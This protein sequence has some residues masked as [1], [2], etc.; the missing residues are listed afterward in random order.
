M[1]ETFERIRNQLN[2]FWQGLDKSKKIKLGV[3]S[4]LL[5]V[6]ITG[7]I[8]FTTRTKY[9]VLYD[10]LT[11]KEAGEITKK[12]DEQG[13]TWKQENKGNTL[14]VPTEM[15]DKAKMDL[16]VEGLP[17]ER[18]SFDNA[19]SDIDWT[20]TEFDK[21]QKMKYALEN[22]LAKD[23]SS[24][25]GIESAEVHMK[26]PEDSGYVI[27]ETD[28]PTA[29]VYLTL[30]KN[31]PIKVSK[32][33]GIQHL[34]ANA[35]GGME[36]Q[37]VSIID[38]KGKL[39]SDNKG[40]DE[41][42]DLN[43]QLAIQQAMQEKLN[44]SIKEFLEKAFGP[45]NV[46]IRTSIKMNFDTEVTNVKEFKPP[47]E[48]SEEGIPRSKEESEESMDNVSGGQVPGTETNAQD[49][50]PEYV[51]TETG[52][53]KYNKNNS[54]I[55]YEINETNKQVK[56]GPGEI[57]SVSVAVLINEDVIGEGLTDEKKKEIT[58]LVSN[59]TAGA[60]TEQVEVSAIS[61]NNGQA[62]SEES[63]ESDGGLPLWAWMLVGALALAG[64]SGAVIY[65][66]KKLQEAEELEQEELENIMEDTIS[67][68]PEMEEIDFGS[69]KSQM[70]EQIS[71]FIDKKPEMV[72]QLLRTWLN[73]E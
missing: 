11:P 27:K 35:V 63:T 30:D 33:K 56:R 23:I 43:N 62:K 29:S 2:E 42:D 21:K 4:L 59:A 3:A 71:K 39:L 54:T 64:V 53:N 19:F 65:R 25:D 22:S 44:T 31:T 67:E 41:I 52:S 40:N 46:D 5:I 57:E 10:N 24:M 17:K 50:A 14:L 26:V 72:A 7:I 28:K 20:T 13:I 36:A 16:A 12:L 49:Q 9:E 37:D 60:R 73:E 58:N 51:Q 1:G 6:G 34:V 15:R 48:G 66:R 45:G 69:E 38:N 47:I 18:Y 32:I 61:F 68:I 55:N 70:K 8:Y